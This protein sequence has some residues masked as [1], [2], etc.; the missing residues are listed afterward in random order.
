MSDQQQ[1]ASEGLELSNQEQYENF[2][3]LY[4]ADDRVLH[5]TL[6]QK[7]EVIILNNSE[8]PQG[9]AVSGGLD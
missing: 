7:L 3:H 4:V 9:Q 1:Q 2:K 6:Q 8:P 5:K